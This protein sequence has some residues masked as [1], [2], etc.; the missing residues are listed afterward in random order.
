MPRFIGSAGY[1]SAVPAVVEHSLSVWE[2][3][4]SVP[5]TKKGGNSNKESTFQVFLKLLNVSFLYKK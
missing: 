3:L 1:T 2:A 5:A 4:D